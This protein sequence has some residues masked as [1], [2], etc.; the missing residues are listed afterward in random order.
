MSY[1]NRWSRDEIDSWP[2]GHKACVTCRRVLP[3]DRFSLAKN[4]IFGRYY[5]CKECRKPESKRYFANRSTEARLLHKAKSRVA[6]SGKEFSI[7]IDDITVPSHCPI[8]GMPLARGT[9]EWYDHSPSLDR[10]DPNKGY[11]PGNVQV[12]SHRA[13]MLKS[14]A[15]LEELEALLTWMKQNANKHTE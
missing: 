10:I 4:G 13:N 12:I 6:K 8:L 3:F 7:N 15:T 2:E 5:Q 9:N 11:V 14:N 1:Q